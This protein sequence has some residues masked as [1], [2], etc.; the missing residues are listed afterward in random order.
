MPLLE[1]SIIPVGTNTPSFSSYVKQVTRLIENRG[2][3]YQ[4][5]PTS[6]VIEGSLDDLM[7]VAKDIH[8][9][10]LAN[11]TNRIITNMSIDDRTDQSLSLH[12]QVEAVTE[13]AT[14]MNM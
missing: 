9:A 3:A 12:R 11:G 4:V 1:I 13:A 14:N 5:T 2:L 8:T 7:D 10:A 6:T